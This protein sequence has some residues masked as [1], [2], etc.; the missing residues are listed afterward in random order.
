MTPRLYKE[1]E[2]LIA[3]ILGAWQHEKKP[4][5]SELARKYGV[6]RKSSP[7]PGMVYALAQHCPQ[8]TVYYL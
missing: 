7:V 5:F 4:N 6:S 8:P 2:K 3:E 1:E